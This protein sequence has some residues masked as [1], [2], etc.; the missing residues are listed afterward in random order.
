MKKYCA[1]CY[2]EIKTKYPSQAKTRKYCSV[3][4]GQIGAHIKQRNRI[5]KK[6]IVCNIDFQIKASHASKRETC[7]Q[8][9]RSVIKSQRMSGENHRYYKKV[10]AE[11]KVF[12][13][14]RIQV[15][16]KSLYLHRYVMEQYLGRK[17]TYNE[18]VHHK[19]NNH[20][21]NSIKNLELVSRSEHTRQHLLNNDIID[22]EAYRNKK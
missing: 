18:V 13:Y 11:K 12:T 20:L 1:I 4:C 15:D 9:C 16:G 2:G 8:K 17:L 21:D 10:K 3:K 19:N 7:S 5:T 14:P 6:C 22:Y